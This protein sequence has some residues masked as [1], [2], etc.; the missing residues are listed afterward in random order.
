MISY[1]LFARIFDLQLVVPCSDVL[2]VSCVFSWICQKLWP[3]SKIAFLL[4]REQRRRVKREKWECVKE[5]NEG[6]EGRASIGEEWQGREERGRGEGRRDCQ[7]RRRKRGDDCKGMRESG[8]DEHSLFI[9][10]VCFIVIWMI[11]VSLKIVSFYVCGTKSVLHA[12]DIRF[13]QNFVN[14]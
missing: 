7:G 2:W 13:S 12:Q 4:S 8:E 14:H 6:S 10:W 1:V 11:F 5:R 3:I 9:Q